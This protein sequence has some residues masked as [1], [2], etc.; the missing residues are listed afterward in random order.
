MM[1]DCWCILF[2]FYIKRILK[3]S[4]HSRR[5]PERHHSYDNSGG[6]SSTDAALGL[7]GIAGAAYVISD[8]K[9]AKTQLTNAKDFTRRRL[10]QL[11]AN[12]N[13]QTPALSTQTLALSTQRSNKFVAFG[14][15]TKKYEPMVI[16]CIQSLKSYYV[17]RWN[18]TNDKCELSPLDK[19]SRC[20]R[21]VFTQIPEIDISI[22][23]SVDEATTKGGDQ[24][25]YT[26]A[27]QILSMMKSWQ[28]SILYL[29]VDCIFHGDP[30]KL[31][32]GVLQQYSDCDVAYFNNEELAGMNYKECSDG[33]KQYQIS[34]FVQFYRYTEA[35]M[36]F[37]QTW[38]DGLF[39]MRC[40][41]I[42][43]ADDEL[44]TALLNNTYPGRTT[45]I[46]I[47]LLNKFADNNKQ[48]SDKLKIIQH[49]DEHLFRKHTLIPLAL[50]DRSNTCNAG[51][52]EV[53][54][55]WSGELLNGRI[56]DGPQVR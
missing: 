30:V 48:S 17:P 42:L 1:F 5:T 14:F 4:R 31:F 15:Y 46:K 3:M 55:W 21:I 19:Q 33:R 7:A 54:F 12:L 41:R 56:E 34:G 18:G 40:T 32:E 38:M 50:S 43:I 2:V 29:D 13:T 39:A 53:K 10:V 52:T 23:G 6:I 35:A 11:C 37:L 24:I 22:I 26:K 45:S 20:E 47:G 28:T 44:L 9:R 27:F 49:P 25:Q 16:R 51:K 8:P 36:H